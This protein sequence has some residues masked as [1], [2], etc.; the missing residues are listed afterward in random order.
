MKIVVGSTNP[1][2]IAAVREV[3]S[4]YASFEDAEIIG[5]NAASEVSDQPKT[6]AE[7]IQGAINRANNAYNHA[8]CDYSIGLES[9]F[10]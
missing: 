9:G 1:S 4:T 6:S 3:F 2:K 5:V 10:H 7:T 8:K